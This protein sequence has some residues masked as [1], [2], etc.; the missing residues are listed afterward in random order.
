MRSI[1]RASVASITKAHD[2]PKEQSDGSL[3]RKNRFFPWNTRHQNVVADS[4]KAEVNPPTE[5]YH[6]RRAGKFID[7]QNAYIRNLTQSGNFHMKLDG[8]CLYGISASQEASLWELQT[9]T[10]SA[11]IT[12]SITRNPLTSAAGEGWLPDHAGF[13]LLSRVA[14]EIIKNIAICNFDNTLVLSECQRE[15]FDRNEL[16]LAR[17]AILANIQTRAN[18]NRAAE[19]TEARIAVSEEHERRFSCALVDYVAAVTAKCA[20]HKD[21]DEP[22]YTLCMASL[23]R[24]T[25]KLKFL[26]VDSQDFASQSL[27]NGQKALATSFTH[28]EAFDTDNFAQ[29][30]SASSWAL[31]SFRSIFSALQYEKTRG[32]L[33][34]T[35]YIG[36]IVWETGWHDVI[37]M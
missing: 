25:A 1:E 21:V 10:L 17:N 33:A 30:F 29:M 6:F 37:A 35:F 18:G 23:A 36:T 12:S 19:T 3:Q 31:E 32:P 14:G 9:T 5:R 27:E 13:E 16:S 20:S 11:A 7:V 28:A 4:P 22:W 8:L 26:T 24:L 2:R 34:D 15:S